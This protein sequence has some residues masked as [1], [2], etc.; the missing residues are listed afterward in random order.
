VTLLETIQALDYPG[1]VV[2][3]SPEDYSA[4]LADERILRALGWSDPSKDLA[5][6]LMTKGGAVLVHSDRIYSH[7][8]EPAEPSEAE[9]DTVLSCLGA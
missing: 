4:L 1:A 3:L 2:W 9:I 6:R 8:P 7:P 5:L